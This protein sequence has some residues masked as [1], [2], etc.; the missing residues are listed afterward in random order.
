MLRSRYSRK[1]AGTRFTWEN[2]NVPFREGTRKSLKNRPN[3]ID[4]KTRSE[5]AQAA[6]KI[7]KRAGYS[8]A[9]TVEFILDDDRHFYFLE[10]NTRLQVEHPVTEMRVG[11]DIVW[12]R[13]GFAHGQPLSVGRK[14]FIFGPCDRMPNLRGGS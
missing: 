2:E 1:S 3:S 11:L 14:T 10:V 7:I 13:S 4:H 12:S 9:G 5:L 6:L 8:N